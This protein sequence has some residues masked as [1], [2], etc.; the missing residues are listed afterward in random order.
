MLSDFLKYTF[1]F[2]IFL[3]LASLLFNYCSLLLLYEFYYFFDNLNILILISLHSSLPRVSSQSTLHTG[4]RGTHGYKGP[5]LLYHFIQ[6][7]WST[8][9]FW[10]PWWS[11][12]QSLEDNERWLIFLSFV[13]LLILSHD[14]K[15]PYVLCNFLSL[16]S[17]SEYLLCTEHGH[18]PAW[19]K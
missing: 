10:Y 16:I 17:F 9:W 6:R 14:V 19:Y 15:L 11:Q 18:G 8:C 12:Y 3:W 7:T 1:K 5:T 2:S 13:F 4:R